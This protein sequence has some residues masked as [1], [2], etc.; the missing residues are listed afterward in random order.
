[1]VAV[2]SQKDYV[3]YTDFGRL[4]QNSKV[5]LHNITLSYMISD[6]L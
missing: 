2:T 1:M 5:Q 4:T 3:E 6:E